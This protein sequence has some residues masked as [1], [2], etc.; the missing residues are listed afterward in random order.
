[1]RNGFQLRIPRP[2]YACAENFKYITAKRKG[3]LLVLLYTSMPQTMASII[4]LKEKSPVKN[5]SLRQTTTDD[6]RRQTTDETAFQ[7]SRL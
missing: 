6:R 7:Y 3:Y 5:Y 1:M 2:K 4:L